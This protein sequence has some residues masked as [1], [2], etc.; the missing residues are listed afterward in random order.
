MA[1]AFKSSFKLF[2]HHLWIAGAGQDEIAEAL[3]QNVLEDS[4]ILHLRACYEHTSR[5]ARILLYCTIETV[6]FLNF[7]GGS[8]IFADNTECTS[9]YSYY[10]TFPLSVDPGEI[11]YL[12]TYPKPTRPL[13]D[14][15]KMIPTSDDGFKEAWEIFRMPGQDKSQECDGNCAVCKYKSVATSTADSLLPDLLAKGQLFNIK[16]S[17]I[18]GVTP[19]DDSE[20]DWSDED[21]VCP[22]TPIDLTDTFDYCQPCEPSAFKASKAQEAKLRCLRVIGEETTYQKRAI[23]DSGATRC[24]V[25]VK[26]DFVSFK[27]RKNASILRGIAAGLSIEGDGIVKYT[28]TDDNNVDFTL[29]LHAFYVPEM[30]N[31]RLISPQGIRTATGLMGGLDAPCNEREDG[32]TDDSISANLYILDEHRPGEHKQAGRKHEV[33]LPYSQK[34]NLPYIKIGLQRPKTE[35][36]A[37]VAELS[38]A[39]DVTAAGNKNLS[40]TQKELLEVHFKLGHCGFKQLQWMARVGRIPVRNATAF[41]NAEPPKCAACQFGKQTRRSVG[42]KPS[43]RFKSL[44]EEVLQLKKNDLLPGQKVSVDHYVSS[45]PGRLNTSRGGTKTSNMYTGGAIFVDHASGYI[46][47]KHQVSLGASDTI[48]S[49][50]SYEQA[51][52]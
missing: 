30:K 28:V 39:L 48:E 32:S 35:T 1:A 49:K 45:L 23:C 33:T 37:L 10:L 25:G 22:S 43:G 16:R 4:L 44:S 42:P 12:L 24:T 5:M 50:L 51:A 40:A 38:K 19:S 36:Q 29:R 47:V 46:D 7:H 27:P 21:T 17:S 2:V 14:F 3:R 26:D 52:H 20:S 18:F 15:R 41:A 34:N 8:L 31:T 6:R 9:A 13:I 11:Y